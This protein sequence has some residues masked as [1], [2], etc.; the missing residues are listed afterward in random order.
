MST[1]TLCYCTVF[2]AIQVFML[3]QARLCKHFSVLD[4]CAQTPF[5]VAGVGVYPYMSGRAFELDAFSS[6]IQLSKQVKLVSILNN[7]RFD[8]SF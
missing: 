1:G 8:D 5:F 7:N 3:R 2:V 6:T 4:W